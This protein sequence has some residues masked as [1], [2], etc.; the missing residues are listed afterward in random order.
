MTIDPEICNFKFSEKG[1]GIVSPPQPVYD[2]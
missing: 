1:L 2:F